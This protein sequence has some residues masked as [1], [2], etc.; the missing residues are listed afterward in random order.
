MGVMSSSGTVWHT[1]RPQCKHFTEPLTLWGS[2]S[3]PEHDFPILFGPGTS[4]MLRN[5]LW[6][7]YT[8]SMELS[9]SSEAASCAA[10]QELPNILWNSKVRYCVHKSPPLVPNPKPDQSTPYYSILRSI[11]ILSTHLRFGLPS[12]LYPSGFPTNNLYAILFACIRATCAAHLIL[13][14][15]IIQIIFEN[16]IHEAKNNK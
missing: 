1:R 5:C 2:G 9:P 15:L 16:V 3:Y 8:N 10:T 6:N 14:G 4:T 7:C 13:L 11:L 12:G